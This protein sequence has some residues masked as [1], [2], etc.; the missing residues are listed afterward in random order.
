MA[1]VSRKSKADEE[2]MKK[3][4]IR[5]TGMDMKKYKKIA[6]FVENIR[7]DTSAKMDES[8]LVTQ[9]AQ[10]CYANYDKEDGLRQAHKFLR[11]LFGAPDLKVL[12]AEGCER[13]LREAALNSKNVMRIVRLNKP[14]Q[15]YHKKLAHYYIGDQLGKGATSVVKQGKDEKTGRLVAIKILT[16]GN[17]KQEDLAKEIDI[18]KQLNHKNVIRLYDCF[19]NVDYPGL[20]K[21]GKKESTTVLVLEMASQGEIFDFFMYSGKFEP[22]LAR[23]FFKQ[24]LEGLDYCHKQGISHRD[25]KPENCM[26]GDGYHVK[27]LDFGFATI[28]KGESGESKMMTALGTPGYAAPEIMKRQKYTKSVDIFS[29]GVVLFITIAGF[30][31]FQEAKDDGTDWWFDKLKK[32]R[33]NLFWRAHERTSSF[34]KDAKEIIQGMLAANPAER[35]TAEKIRKSKWWNGP[36]MT[37]KEAI[38]VLLKRKEKVT[39]EKIQKG[40]VDVDLG[41]HRATQFD[42]RAPALGAFRPA[43]AFMTL[44]GVGAK[45]MRKALQDKITNEFLGKVEREYQITGTAERPSAPEGW[46]EEKNDK[47]ELN[48]PEDWQPWYDLNF[49][50]TLV[51]QNNDVKEEYKFEASVYIREDPDFKPTKENPDFQR[52]IVF[53]KRHQ[54]KHTSWGKLLFEIQRSVGGFFAGDQ[55]PKVGPLLLGPA[56][57]EL[58]DEEK[59]GLP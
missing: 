30:P 45:A 22:E 11:V 4:H 42:K 3:N 49:Y 48:K 14:I 6:S 15:G 39:Q 23:W 25:L 34:S 44:P 12:V 40:A 19:E 7:K 36:T 53:F 46:T 24:M 29:L 10:K 33:Y 2:L 59:A 37:Q 27:L 8:Y 1:D 43:N 41:A 54:G 17:F 20:T 28:F 35:W 31:P 38:D 51:F 56:P 57:V 55:G 9:F 18:L 47:G 21:K 32:K 52:H 13:A 50:C 58:E 26:L 16:G 5:S